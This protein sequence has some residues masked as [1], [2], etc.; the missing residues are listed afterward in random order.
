MEAQA[1]K[2]EWVALG[3]FKIRELDSDD[4]EHVPEHIIE[5]IPE[6]EDVVD[7]VPV[8]DIQDDP[9]KTRSKFDAI[10]NSKEF[11]ERSQRQIPLPQQP[12]LRRVEGF[13]QDPSS[14]EAL[15]K[16]GRYNFL[17]SCAIFFDKRGNQM[18][19]SMLTSLSR[20]YS[21]PLRSK[22]MTTLSH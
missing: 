1:R 22:S 13:Q 17:S 3:T 19:R 12:L 8:Q 10:L 2:N 21:Y 11:R 5:H 16:T 18:L 6:E 15:G 9:P 7:E 14:W 20:T 4:N